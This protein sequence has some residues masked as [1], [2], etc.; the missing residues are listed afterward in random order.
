LVG[1]LDGRFDPDHFEIALYAARRYQFAKHPIFTIRRKGGKTA[2]EEPEYPV[3]KV[4]DPKKYV[5]LKETVTRLYRE[6]EKG[7]PH[8]G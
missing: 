2:V 7:L 1:E 4:L 3:R 5:R 6:M 8:G